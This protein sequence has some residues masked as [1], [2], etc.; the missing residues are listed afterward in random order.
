VIVA[1]RRQL[2]GDEMIGVDSPASVD[3]CR[4]LLERPGGVEL[5]QSEPRGE[6]ASLAPR[7]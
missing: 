7:D 3:D 2:P 4:Q 5:A 6:R 1:Q